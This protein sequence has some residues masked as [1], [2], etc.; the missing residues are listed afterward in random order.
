[1]EAVCLSETLETAYQIAQYRMLCAFCG[2]AQRY[3]V[4]DG[5]MRNNWADLFL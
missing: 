3:A 1:M 4:V 2:G 5:Q